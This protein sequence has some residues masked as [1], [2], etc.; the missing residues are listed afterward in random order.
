MVTDVMGCRHANEESV[1]GW[2]CEVRDAES[3]AEQMGWVSEMDAS[4]LN[5][6][7]GKVRR[8]IEEQFS[9]ERVV[10]AYLDYLSV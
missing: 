3:L 6:A 9:D 2:L 4:Q 1:T 5:R 10:E 8:R 7:G